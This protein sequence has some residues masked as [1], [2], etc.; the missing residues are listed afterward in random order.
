MEFSN[1]DDM[2]EFGAVEIRYIPDY[3]STQENNINRKKTDNKTKKQKEDSI[4]TYMFNDEHALNMH[5]PTLAEL[6]M[7]K[8]RKENQFLK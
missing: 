3:T 8:R 2:I 1:T 4:I 6:F 7:K 5:R